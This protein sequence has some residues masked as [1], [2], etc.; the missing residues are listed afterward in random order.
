MA[1]SGNPRSTG[2]TL[3]GVLAGAAIGAAVA[4][5]RT[6]GTGEEN[7]RRVAGLAKARAE[8]ARQKAEAQA[9]ELRAKAEARV[10]TI[11]DKAQDAVSGA[12][13]TADDQAV[14]IAPA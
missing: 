8:E 13:E 12:Q 4:L 5:T 7:R 9:A 3:M 10:E 2:L 6:P 14:R 1:R 11:K